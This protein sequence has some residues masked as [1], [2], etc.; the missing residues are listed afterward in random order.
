MVVRSK[1]S[2]AYVRKKPPL[3]GQALT[4]WNQTPPYCS[5]DSISVPSGTVAA[6]SSGDATLTTTGKPGSCVAIISPHACSPGVIE[7][8]IDF[9]ALPGKPNTIADWTSFWLTNQVACPVDGELD[10]VEAAPVNEKNAVS[11]HSGPNTSPVFVASTDGF[12]PA[13]LPVQG[14][15]LTPGWHAVDIVY[16][17]GSFAVYYDGHQ[18]TRYASGKVTGS[19]RVWSYR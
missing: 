2:P 4:S 10:A 5:S 17:K 9:P 12:H 8:D 16:A 3:P 19:A 7:A 1:Q 18:Y 15:N 6:D 14:P 11:W 13:K